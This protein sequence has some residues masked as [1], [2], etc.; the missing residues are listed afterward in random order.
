[1]A[2]RWL[3]VWPVLAASTFAWPLQASAQL[4][5][6]AIAKKAIP[7][8]VF[9]K[10]ITTDGKQSTASGFLV[11]S[12]GTIVTNFH[13]VQGMK[14]LAIKV[15]NGDIYDQVRIRAFDERKD[16]AIIQVQGFGLP[17]LELGDSD[18]LQ[19][20]AP[21]TLVGNPLGLEG[22]SVD[23]S[24]ERHSKRRRVSSDPDRRC[25]KSREQRRPFARQQ[26]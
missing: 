15:P 9:I 16:L 22:F 13:V 8:V 26:W 23:R 4:T 17:S 11:D 19:P 12:S 10:G 2:L 7:A 1:M 6:A 24:G 18:D 14:A 20:G 25:G 5:P 21:V 3:V